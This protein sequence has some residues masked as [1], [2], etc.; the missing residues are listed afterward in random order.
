[1]STYALIHVDF[2]TDRD[3]HKITKEPPSILLD[4]L[5]ISS[6]VV[7][8]VTKQ[9]THS[10]K[11]FTVFKEWLNLNPDATVADLAKCLRQADLDKIADQPQKSIS[12]PPD[13]AVNTDAVTNMKGKTA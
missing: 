13:V 8:K 1:M 10:D 4:P 7:S 9:A 12:T 2:V 11:I 3:L 5:G 6:D